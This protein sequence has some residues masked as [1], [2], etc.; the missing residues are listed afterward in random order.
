MSSQTTATTRSERQRGGGLQAVTRTAANIIGNCSIRD[1]SAVLDQGGIPEELQG[2]QFADIDILHDELDVLGISNCKFVLSD[3]GFVT[4]PDPE[5]KR[6]TRSLRKELD[7]YC[8]GW[9]GLCGWGVCDQDNV[10]QINK[11]TPSGENCKAGT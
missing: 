2:R 7:K 3:D 9:P 1:G 6:A 4:M 8:K 10:Q 5:H 11:L